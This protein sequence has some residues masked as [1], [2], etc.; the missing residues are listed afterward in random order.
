MSTNVPPGTDV[1]GIEAQ[2][3]DIIARQDTAQSMGS[4]L[5]NVVI[6]IRNAIGAIDQYPA[7][8]T[9]KR[10][11]AKS[12]LTQ[13]GDLPDP[14]LPEANYTCGGIA[15][16]V[17]CTG[18][19]EIGNG[20]VDGTT[21]KVYTPLFDVPLSSYGLLSLQHASNGRVL[22][23]CYASSFNDI[24]IG[25]DYG[26]VNTPS[27]IRMR[28]QTLFNGSEN[29]FPNV[30]MDNMLEVT[31][32]PG[33]PFCGS[34]QVHG[35]TTGFFE[36]GDIIAEYYILMPLNST[37]PPSLNFYIAQGYVSHPS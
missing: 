14:T 17:K 5:N 35:M 28:G 30:N 2:L 18:Y 23:R 10:L 16:W 31:L 7:N 36:D 32:N 24:A 21:F 12:V 11:L 27:M 4:T 37:S 34:M 20:I 6:D 8:Y 22:Y 3:N 26:E 13:G 29:W 9:I 19:N 15:Q 25:W 33:T 1:S